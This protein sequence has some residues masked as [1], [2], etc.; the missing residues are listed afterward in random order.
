M[1]ISNCLKI[2]FSFDLK[3]KRVIAADCGSFFTVVI[4]LICSLSLSTIH[5]ILL[6]LLLLMKVSQ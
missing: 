5:K 1:T 2:V 6:I 4:I 3:A